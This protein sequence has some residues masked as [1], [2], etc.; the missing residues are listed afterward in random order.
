[1][2]LTFD[3]HSGHIL[4]CIFHLK[5]H[6]RRVWASLV[7]FPHLSL[8]STLSSIT[9]PSSN[10]NLYPQVIALRQNLSLLDMS[11]NNV[12]VST[13]VPLARLVFSLVIDDTTHLTR[14]PCETEQAPSANEPTATKMQQVNTSVSLQV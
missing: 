5:Q 12:R 6:F 2:R 11:H 8:S 9:T 13:V 10:L 4:R 7:C 14:L 1:M 3:L